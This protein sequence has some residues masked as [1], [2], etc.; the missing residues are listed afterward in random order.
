MAY[1]TVSHYLHGDSWGTTYG[2]G[3]ISPEQ[4]TDEVWDYVFARKDLEPS[5]VE[6]RAISVSTLQSM[7]REFEYWYPVDVNVSGKDLI[8]NH[9]V[10]TARE[11][12]RDTQTIP[13]RRS[14]STSTPLSGKNNPSFGLA[15]FASTAIFS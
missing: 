7:R 10:S 8:D 9:L 11:H 5:Q 12:D 14:S 1:Y 13:S 2:I 15:L 4:L 6:G 3:K